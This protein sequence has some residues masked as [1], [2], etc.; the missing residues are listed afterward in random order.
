MQAVNE[1]GYIHRDLKFENTFLSPAGHLVVGDFTT[2]INAARYE[3][4]GSEAW[5]AAPVHAETKPIGTPFRYAPEQLYA[6]TYTS[7]VDLW[8]IGLMM[9]ELFRGNCTDI[10][11]RPS[12]RDEHPGSFDIQTKDLRPE[13]DTFVDDEHARRLVR[14]L[15]SRA[16]DARPSIRQIMHDPYFTPGREQDVKEY[17][18]MIKNGD[19]PALYRPPKIVVPK[20]SKIEQ[21]FKTPRRWQQALPLEPGFDPEH[22]AYHYECEE[23]LLVLDEKIYGT[24][25]VV[26]A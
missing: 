11:F 7:K 2:V 23:S 1:M 24:L 18:Q 5:L 19:N 13:I 26:D 15:L 3:R 4:P 14:R 12:E 10:I 25:A 22:R 6:K 9:L 8:A 17:W 16:P 20:A 21:F